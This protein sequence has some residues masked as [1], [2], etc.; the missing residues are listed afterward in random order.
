MSK[1]ILKYTEGHSTHKDYGSTIEF[2]EFKA[3]PQLRQNGDIV[4]L[5]SNKMRDLFKDLK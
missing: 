5:V 2:Y 3:T 4:L 1:I